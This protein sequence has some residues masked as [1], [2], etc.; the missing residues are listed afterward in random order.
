MTDLRQ[1]QLNPVGINCLRDFP[2]IGTVVYGARTTVT[3]T[4]EQSRYVPVRRMTLFL[5]QTLY[6][7]LGWVV[8][9]PAWGTMNR[10]G[11]RSR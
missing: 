11:R 5:E 3:M 6:A 4:D 10:C 2:N 7:N 1:G 8:F 9:E